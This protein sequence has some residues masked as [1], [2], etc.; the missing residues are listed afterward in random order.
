MNRDDWN[1]LIGAAIFAIALTLALPAFA[2]EPKL[3]PGVTC[4]DVRAKVAEMGKIRALAFALEN[5]ATWRD[6]REAR[7]CLAR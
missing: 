5:G 7:K 4:A 2:S 3:P 1:A 6:I